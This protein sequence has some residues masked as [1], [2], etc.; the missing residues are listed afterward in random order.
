M[1]NIHNI[2][3]IHSIHNIHTMTLILREYDNAMVLQSC[4]IKVVWC[5]NLVNLIIL[6]ASHVAMLEYCSYTTVKYIV[7]LQYDYIVIF[8]IL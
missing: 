1:H 5:S 6:E 4:N 8:I 2:H 7:I 3:N